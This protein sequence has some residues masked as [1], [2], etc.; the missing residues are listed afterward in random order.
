MKYFNLVCEDCR[1]EQ[2]TEMNDINIDFYFN[3]N[4]GKIQC[5]TCTKILQL[6]FEDGFDSEEEL[7]IHNLVEKLKNK[8]MEYVV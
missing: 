7:L 1:I 2:W 4:T 5:P 8:E 3:K 6:K